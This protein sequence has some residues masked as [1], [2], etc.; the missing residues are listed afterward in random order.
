MV[1]E[2]FYWTTGFKRLLCTAGDS[3]HFLELDGHKGCD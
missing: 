1:L 2:Q 3:V